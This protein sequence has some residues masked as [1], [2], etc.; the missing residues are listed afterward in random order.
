MI[1][2][3]KIIEKWSSIMGKLTNENITDLSSMSSKNINSIQD[4]LN[5]NDYN[6]TNFSSITFPIAQR[7][8][9]YTLAGGG[10]RKSKKQQLKEDRINKLKELKGEE[11][12]VVLPDDEEFD[13]LVSV[14]PMSSPCT[15]LLYMDFVYDYWDPIKKLK[16][17][18]ISK[19]DKINISFRKSKLKYIEKIIK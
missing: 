17:D 14:M 6:R 15:S 1:E 4:E 19:L 3:E 13:G 11:P 12:N 2:K 7:I 10:M 5:A 9:S 18:R 16:D 8:M